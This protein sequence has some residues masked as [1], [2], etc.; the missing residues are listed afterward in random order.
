MNVLLIILIII[1]GFI[2]YQL[3]RRNE[4]IKAEIIN[5]KESEKQKEVDELLK[6]QYPHIFFDFKEEIRNY[7]EDSQRVQEREKGA[8]EYAEKPENISWGD[9]LGDN[10]DLSTN[11]L[12]MIRYLKEE[13]KDNK[14]KIEYFDKLDK[15]FAEIYQKAKK[16]SILTERELWFF[17]YKFWKKILDDEKSEK[18]EDKN[19]FLDTKYKLIIDSYSDLL[20]QYKKK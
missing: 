6:A 9:L 15:S 18:P 10:Y 5:V 17:C 16:E 2:G 8:I 14:K 1:L 4:L 3:Y 19:Q 11:P 20:N 12:T 13:N 7:Y